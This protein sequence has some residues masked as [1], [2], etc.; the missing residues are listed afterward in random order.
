[1]AVSLREVFTPFFNYIVLFA[2]TPG[3]QQRAFLARAAL[4]KLSAWVD[5]TDDAF[6]I[7][8]KRNRSPTASLEVRPPAPQSG[9]V[10]IERYWESEPEPVA[11]HAHPLKA[12]ISGR[13][14]MKDSD[15]GEPSAGVLAVEL[16]QRRRRC[17]TVRA[18]FRPPADQDDFAAQHLHIKRPRVQPV[19]KLERGRGEPQPV[20][21]T[22]EVGRCGRLMDGQQQDS[23]TFARSNIRQVREE[24]LQPVSR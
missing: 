11:C 20:I 16:P 17:H 22:A 21:S 23:N 2:R 9:P 10:P 5:I 3:Q 24:T 18:A 14:R 19:L 13:F 12:P 1:M 7:D 6:L 4:V 8:D 15:H